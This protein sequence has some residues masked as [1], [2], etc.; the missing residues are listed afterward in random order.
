MLAP[1]VAPQVTR[2][3]PRFSASSESLKVSGAGVL[4]HDV[5]AALARQPA[6]D[7]GEAVLAV[8]DD[9]VAPSA[10]A[11]SALSASP[12]VVMTLAPIALA[13]VIAAVPNAR[14]AGLDQHGLA[15]FEPGVVEEHMF[16]GREGDRRAGGLHHRHP[17]RHGDEQRLGTFTI[18]AAK[19]STWKAHDAAHVLAVVVAPLAAGL[20]HPAGERAVDRDGLADRDIVRT[21]AE[22]DHLARG[23]RADDQRQLCAWRKPC[24]GNPRRRCG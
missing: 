1:E 17:L 12:T 9:V 2:R 6:R 7:R 5:D 21:F 8:V 19:P 24:R 23:F 22:R 20:A 13:S 10:F 3:P 15:A 11:F 4:E 16:D 18:S 14:A